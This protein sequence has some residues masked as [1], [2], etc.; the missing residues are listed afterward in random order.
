MTT[1]LACLPA[2]WLLVIGA[3]IA[4]D[5][6]TL[7][8]DPD[9]VLATTGLALVIGVVPALIAIVHHHATIARAPSRSL[10]VVITAYVVAPVALL[11]T[12]PAF[13][14]A[15]GDVVAVSRWERAHGDAPPTALEVRDEMQSLVRDT[16]T[17]AGGSWTALSNGPAPSECAMPD[18]SSGVDWSWDQQRAGPD[19]PAGLVHAVIASWEAA[20]LTTSHVKDSI[21][22]GRPLYRVLTSAPGVQSISVNATARR[23]SIEVQSTCGAGDIDDYQ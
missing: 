5:F 3:A 11:T 6:S 16:M 9:A 10:R 15:V 4:R 18:G 14:A 22:D 13:G 1:L 12:G 2:A 8:P 23:V 21:D 17:A 19:N 20:G 7:D